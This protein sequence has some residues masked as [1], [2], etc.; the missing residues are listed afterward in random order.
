MNNVNSDLKASS[1]FEYQRTG[2]G[3]HPVKVSEY[4]GLRKNNKMPY[5]VLVIETTDNYRP[6]S[7]NNTY[8]MI[9]DL[10]LEEF[11]KKYI[12][13]KEVFRLGHFSKPAT[14]SGGKRRRRSTKKARKTR[15]RSKK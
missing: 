4:S 15:R 14:T 11:I 2:G 13:G 3:A 6:G 7:W 5:Q 10:T 8:V 12:E 9:N 1:T